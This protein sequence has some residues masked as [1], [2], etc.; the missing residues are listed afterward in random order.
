MVDIVFI[1]DEE[2]LVPIVKT[3][4]YVT[5]QAL[6]KLFLRHWIVA[7]VVKHLVGAHCSEIAS[8]GQFTFDFF[9]LFLNINLF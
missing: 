8:N 3:I 2:D 6:S 9:H 1:E 7:S 5:E 4:A